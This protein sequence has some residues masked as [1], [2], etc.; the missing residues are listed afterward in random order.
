MKSEMVLLKMDE[1]Q[2][3]AWFMANRGTLIAHVHS[4]FNTSHAAINQTNLRPAANA[5]SMTGV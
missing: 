4:K 5:S 2:R 1:R 3:L